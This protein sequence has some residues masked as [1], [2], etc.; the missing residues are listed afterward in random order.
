[1]Y[2]VGKHDAISNGEVRHLITRA[3]LEAVSTEDLSVRILRGGYS[4]ALVALCA[5]SELS[6]VV[7][8]FGPMEKIEAEHRN[9]L[10]YMGEDAWLEEHG[11]NELFAPVEIEIEHRKVEWSM[12][13]YRYRGGGS[14]EELKHFN[15][16]EG[17]IGSYLW[18]SDRD[19]APSDNTVSECF[20]A[21]A[22]TLGADRG[23]TQGG[24]LQS[25]AEYVPSVDWEEGVSAVIRTA[26]AF[27][28]DLNELNGL[29]EW[30]DE[31]LNGVLFAPVHDRRRLH[32]DARFANVLVD[33][34][35][36]EVHLI[37]FGSGRLGHVFEDFARF[38]L[39]LLFKSVP[40]VNGSQE[41]DRAQL[42]TAVNFVLRDEVNLGNEELSSRSLKCLRLW[43]NAM[44][45]SFP[46]LKHSGG[47]MMYRWFLLGECLKRT[48][49]VNIDTAVL[50]FTI[51]AL[52]QY[53]SDGALDSTWI[54]N[55]PQSLASQ[56]QCRA[57]YVPTRGSERLVN[58]M[59][60]DAK[61]GA[62]SDHDRRK[63]AVRLLAETGQSYLSPRGVFSNEVRDVL[64]DGGRLQVV[65]L[66]PLLTEYLGLSA[67]YGGSGEDGYQAN[68]LLERK[69]QESIRGYQILEAEFGTAVELRLARF[70]LAQTILLTSGSSFLE[71]YFRYARIE[72]ERLLFDSFELE[73]EGTGTHSRSLL[74][75]TFSFHWAHSD[76]CVPVKNTKGKHGK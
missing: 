33:D 38:E 16:F 71:P 6:P 2:I 45:R 27:C 35:R 32:G 61:K 66:N 25:L 21:M 17:F 46:Q 1:M 68:E 73:L 11:L 12:I 9:R 49:W 26:A 54:S 10:A 8:K 30:W 19:A 63:S 43:R 37:D 18:S 42:V 51:C 41:V 70:G 44:C 7:L 20:R 48:T 59:R 65:I 58:N 64:R 13:A 69:T 75:E 5:S 14:F 53:L 31:N 56:L 39:D 55:A 62:L 60:N 3:L 24:P 23:I 50:I 22:F 72:R 28:P 74:E 76:T 47:L 67:C 34:V 4:D 40:K 29:R 36:S 15:D 52:R 57:A